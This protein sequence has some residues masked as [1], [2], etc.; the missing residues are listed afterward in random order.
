M[1][2]GSEQRITLAPVDVIR[3]LDP[4]RHLVPARAI[5]TELYPR[6][7]LYENGLGG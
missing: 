5:Y 4:R 6:E 2:I 1:E 3:L 7:A